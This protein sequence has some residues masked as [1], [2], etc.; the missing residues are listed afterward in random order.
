MET[1]ARALP[2][3][4]L[5]AYEIINPDDFEWEVTTYRFVRTDKGRQTHEDRGEIKRAMWDLFRQHKAR[6]HGDRFVIDTDAFTVAVPEGWDIP[7]PT[8]Q[9]G[10]KLLG[11]EPSWRKRATLEAKQWWLVLSVKA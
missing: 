11:S 6:C 3:N 8:I 7:T 4:F 5:N 10:T 2:E 1:G 9:G